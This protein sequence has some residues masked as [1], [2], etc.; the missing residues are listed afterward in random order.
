MRVEI[1]RHDWSLLRSLWREDSLVLRAALLELCEAVSETDVD[2]AVQRI[3]DETA[4]QGDL[5]ESSAAAA[6]CLVHGT[7]SLN[8]YA[9][10][11]SLETL[12]VI[13]SVALTML[14]SGAGAIAEKCLREIRIGFPAYCEILETSKSLDCGSSAVDLLLVCG[15]SDAG[16]RPVARFALQAA[17]DSGDLAELGD[18]ISA[19]IAE[20]DQ[21]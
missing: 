13:G 18:L 15:L 21:E 8:G 11:R 7:Y 6:R 17:M 9:L 10:A 3:E 1:A 19:S 14:L 12:S 2:L 20:L 4:A 5:S 16:L